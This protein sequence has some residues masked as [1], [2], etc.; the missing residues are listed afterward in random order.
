VLSSGTKGTYV[1]VSTRDMD[2][3]SIMWTCS[4]HS[5]SVLSD[6]ECWLLFKQYE[7]E[8][9]KEECVVLVA[10]GKEIVKKWGRLPLEAQ[11]LGS[12]MNSRSG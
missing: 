4:T 5:L 1:L 2:I 9:D 6:D 3:A 10:I 7:F 8:H 12:L 11:A